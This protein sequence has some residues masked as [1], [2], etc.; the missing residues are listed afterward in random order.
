MFDPS[1]L[2]EAFNAKKAGITAFPGA[3]MLAVEGVPWKVLTLLGALVAPTGT[4]LYYGGTVVGEVRAYRS[5][6]DLQIEALAANVALEFKARDDKLNFVYTR[7]TQGERFTKQDGDK[8][9]SRIDRLEH[10]CQDLKS[11][12]DIYHGDL[13]GTMFDGSYAIG[14]KK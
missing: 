5:Q 14:T 8:H 3:V 10:N 7:A 11:K 6:V 2:G 9:E 13:R 1:V 12:I 4:M